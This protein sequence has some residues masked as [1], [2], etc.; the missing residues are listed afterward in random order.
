MRL[1]KEQW[2]WLL[3]DPGN[4]AFALL[5]RA[6]FAP[7]VFMSCV[8]GVWSESSATANWGLLCSFSGVAA[9]ALSLYFGAL[10]DGR[11]K[12]KL[13]LLISTVIGV[14]AS[15]ML[16]FS[17]DYRWIMVIYFIGLAAYMVGNSFYDSLLISVAKPVEYSKLSTMAYGFGYMGGFLPFIIILGVGLWLKNKLLTA[18]IAFIFAGVWWFLWS[19][20][21]FFKVKESTAG[22]HSMRWFDGFKQLYESLKKVFSDRNARLFLIAYFLYIDGVST[23]LLM[24]APLSVSIGMSEVMFMGAILALQFIGFPA[25][26]GVGALAGRIGTRKVVYGL[27]AI[28][29]TVAALVGAISL[30]TG[31]TVKLTLFLVVAFLIALAQGGIQSLSRSLFGTLVPPERA[32]EYFS[33]YNIFGKFTTLLGPILIYLAS[34]WWHKSE[35]GIVLLIVP[36]VLGGT[37]LARVKFPETKN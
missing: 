33:V 36:F 16:A 31:Y 34:M 11:S 10:A 2:C 7:L 1:N 20:P 6:V 29:T 21:L 23:I 19:L 13:A 4:A 5:V 17:H 25:T 26:V 12:R 37:M 27:L 35:Y 22:Q 32:A 9:G 30:S 15:V 3:Y 18:Q 14:A 8:K 24:A 28:Y